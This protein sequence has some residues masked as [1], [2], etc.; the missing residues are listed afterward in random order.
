MTIDW[1]LIDTALLGAYPQ[2]DETL[3]SLQG[4]ENLSIY[5]GK[6]SKM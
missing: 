1:G 6:F 3:L 5:D 4:P 2:L